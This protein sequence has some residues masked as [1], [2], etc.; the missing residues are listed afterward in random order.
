M[1][2]IDKFILHVVHN[3]KNELNE[4]YSESAVK[5]FIKQFREEADDLNIQITDEQ[6]RKYIERFDVIKNSPKI[7][8]KDLGK[9]S[10]G[11]LIRL[12]TASK[13]AETQD[14]E[15]DR[16]PDVVYQDGGITIWN[17]SK[18]DN[19]ITYGRGER[20]CITR[21]S[22]GN[23]RYDASKGYPT[24][25]LAKNTNLS[26]SDKLSFV[27]IQVRD[28]RSESDRY[29]YTNRQNS[30]YQSNPM[31]FSRLMSEIPWL[32]DIPNIQSILKYIPLSN[33]EKITQTYK[34]NAISIREW[35]KLPFETKKQYLVVRQGKS[36]FEDISDSEFVSKYLPQ[37]P[38]IAENQLHRVATLDNEFVLALAYI[39]FCGFFMN[40]EHST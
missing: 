33:K 38:Q 37:Y 30:P 20:W 4:A 1:R 27:A 19:C 16:T 18:E 36:F 35:I 15:E 3:W 40:K 23:Y 28:T 14:D 24:F 21:G 12:V 7:P 17:G 32:R 25:Y 34:N 9:W 10:L 11:A 29:V 8:E 5:Q 2:P 31:N 22:Y 13:G 26:D 39:E 6:L